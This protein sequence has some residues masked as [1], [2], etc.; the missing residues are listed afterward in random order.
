M[1]PKPGLPWLMWTGAARLAS[2]VTSTS[3]SAALRHASRL[4]CGSL[5]RAASRYSAV[6]GVGHRTLGLTS[7]I[8]RIVPR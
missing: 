7:I 1:C 6:A 5:G 8:H 3:R 2:V 4:V